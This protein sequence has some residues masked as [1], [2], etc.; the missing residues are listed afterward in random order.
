LIVADV[1]LLVYQAVQTPQ[2][3]LAERWADHDPHWFVPELWRF[4]FTNAI[5]TLARNGRLDHDTAASVISNAIE[6]FSPRELPVDQVA[7]YRTAVRYRISSYDAN[8]I[9]LAETLGTYCVTADRQMLERVPRLTKP[10]S[11]TD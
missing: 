6:A 4:E 11:G 7:V 3:R 5:T 10:L 1:N 8:Y 9:V 2:T